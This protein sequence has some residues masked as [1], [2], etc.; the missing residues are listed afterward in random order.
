MWN[1]VC[2]TRLLLELHAI[3]M[4]KLDFELGGKGFQVGGFLL[5]F[6]S[7]VLADLKGVKYSAAIMCKR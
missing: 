5:D 3:A 1:Q 4:L 6:L 2:R 7:Q